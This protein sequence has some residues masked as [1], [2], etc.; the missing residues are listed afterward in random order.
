MY[1]E[2]LVP[3]DGSKTAET[4]L[5]NVVRITRES[6]SK[7][8]LFTVDASDSSGGKG[9]SSWSDMG[10][11]LATLKKPDAAMKAYLDSAAN[12][13]SELGVDALTATA[14][15]DA[16]AAIL[17]YANDNG[18]DLI[19]MSTR[20]R[21]ALRRGLIGSVADAVV[22]ASKVPVL[23]AAYKA[24]TWTAR[25]VAWPCLLTDQRWLKLSCLTWKDWRRCFLR[26]SF[27]FE[28]FGWF[29]GCTARTSECRWTPQRL[30]RPWSWRHGNI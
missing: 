4:I 11:A 21:S 9:A 27:C 29:P 30:K 7:V 1:A 2:I 16:A 25:F 14:D 6:K 13:L 12:M 17:A 19:A 20:G 18:C 10:N 26:K 28:L 5:P 15:G 8:V 22:R 23:A 24:K 3:L